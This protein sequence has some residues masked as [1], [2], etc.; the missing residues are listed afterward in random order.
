MTSVTIHLVRHGE[1]D[2]PQGVLYERIPGFHLSGRGLRMAEAT[3]QFLAND[4]KTRKSCAVFS[5]PLER[6]CETA[7]KIKEKLNKVRLSEGRPQL[8][9]QTDERLIEAEN[10]FRGQKVSKRTLINPK[11]FGKLSNFWK[12]GWG[13]A[14]KQIADRMASFTFEKADLYPGQQIIAV[15]HEAPIWTFR[16]LMEKGRAEHNILRRHT[17]LASVTSITF[18]SETHQV[19]DISYADPAADV[20]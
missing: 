9:I 13:E 18:D 11:N 3:A 20:K 7:E 4:E 16:H 17:A 8:N 1:V 12:P 2:N 19:L 14:Y 10:K 5:S 15:S 6:A